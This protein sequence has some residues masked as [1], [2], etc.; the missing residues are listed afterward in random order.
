MAVDTLARAL[1]A[2][3]VP[4][5][6]YE[7][8]VA[9]GYTGTK[10]QFEAD[11]GQSG[12]NATNAA[13]SASAAAAS[14]TAAASAATNIASGYSDNSPYRVGD[15]VLYNGGLYECITAIPS[16]EAW[17]AEHWTAVKVGTELTNLNGLADDT[18][19]SLFDLL[20]GYPEV[21]QEYEPGNLGKT[22]ATSSNTAYIRTAD[23]TLQKVR[24]GDCVISD[25]TYYI[26]VGIYNSATLAAT[27]FVGWA[28]GDNY[29]NIADHG[30]KCRTVVIP[31]EYA[32][33][34][35]AIV[36]FTDEDTDISAQASGLSA[37][38]KVVRLGYRKIGYERSLTSSDD[39]NTLL[40]PGVYALTSGNLPANM[41]DGVTTGIVMV[42]GSE[43]N[44]R[45]I[46]TIVTVGAKT[47][48]RSLTNTTQSSWI[49][50]AD[51]NALDT[52][53]FNQQTDEKY[54]AEISGTLFNTEFE[55]QNISL[56]MGGVNPTSGANQSD[57]NPAL[58][59]TGYFK[60]PV[61]QSILFSLN[62]ADYEWTIWSY[63][64]KTIGT[65]THSD[66]FE[67]WL[68]CAQPVL[69]SYVSGDKYFRIAFR[70]ADGADLTT[71]TSD[72]ESD[73][74]VIL[75]KL[76]GSYHAEASESLNKIN[77]SRIKG[78]LNVSVTHNDDGTLTAST[79]SNGE[80][81]YFR[82]LSDVS[83]LKPG[84]VYALL[85]RIESMGGSA[86]VCYMRFR[87]TIDGANKLGI[88][89]GQMQSPGEYAAF[90]RATGYETRLDFLITGGTSA[91]AT[92][93]I[94]RLMLVETDISLPYVPYGIS[95]DA[96]LPAVGVAADAKV[97]GVQN[98]LAHSVQYA[99]AVWTPTADMPS[100]FTIETS[101]EVKKYFAEG[102]AVIGIPYSSA[103]G[104]DK[105]IGPQIS[106]HTFLSAVTNPRSVLYTRKLNY[107]NAGTYYGC[108]C[109][110]YV[111]HNYNFNVNYV[112]AELNEWDE[113]EPINLVDLMPGDILL[114]GWHVR[115]VTFVYRDQY[116][117]ISSVGW[118]EAG[119]PCVK[120]T[121]ALPWDKFVENINSIRPDHTAEEDVYY[122]FRYKRI[123][124]V[125]YRREPESIGYPDETAE[126]ITYPDIM[127]EYGDQAVLLEGESTKINVIDGTGY[128]TIQITRDGVSF[129]TR[130]TIAD[131]KMEG[132]NPG[133][134]E[135]T[136][137][138]VGKS[139]KT[140][141][142]VCQ[143]TCSFNSESKTLTFSSS[144]SKPIVIY[145]Y[146]IETRGETLVPTN[147]NVE[148]EAGDMT[149]SGGMWSGSKDLTDNMVIDGNLEYP[150]VKIAFA[151]NDH[152]DWGVATWY[153]PGE[154]PK[155]QDL[156][157]PWPE[158]SES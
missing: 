19:D 24:A 114:N 11:M 17:N 116:G 97:W 28:T 65:A 140:E 73:Y 10:E 14:A 1:A 44:Y 66:T 32:D 134:Y 51:A 29:T 34:Y 39:M 130:T 68:N 6:A 33:K 53:A 144:N 89:I 79:N 132:L 40:T 131:F 25:G 150:F 120:D 155:D 47:L 91:D 37:H 135:I 84:T 93:V 20:S 127:S 156:W 46:Q 16:K 158:P 57:S 90:Y 69:A 123:N 78:N 100:Q 12:T 103:R 49:Q 67:Q 26:R 113:L 85:A 145:V 94:S 38:I 22:G 23:G 3:K 9:G 149:Y 126:Q 59:R 41:P 138:G 104:V 74:S 72:P 88:G 75:S 154:T 133:L 45:R 143:A 56:V 136:M 92:V 124:D 146:K 36:A 30:R 151:P 63:S 76:V 106:L 77:F 70:R 129:A 52:V 21:A 5:D 128:D 98:A 64:G 117:R 15:H 8:A 83:F 80:H 115:F 7:M 60:L 122:P 71:D 109:S 48:T 101:P 95:S 42:Y 121:L 50:T 110:A 54:I 2:G 112:T 102:K 62:D 86:Q 153:M 35:A 99:H 105:L 125:T 108:V 81:R 141:F 13:E 107:N 111:A 142:F 61:Y 96:L 27:N 87:G 139:T 157:K 118:S 119:E 31:A 43:N 148:L 58:C 4:V 55:P 147:R 152:P 137:T 82:C 18:G